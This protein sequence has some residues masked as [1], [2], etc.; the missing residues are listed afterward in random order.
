MGLPSLFRVSFAV[1]VVVL[2]VLIH[3]LTAATIN[4][5][6]VGGATASGH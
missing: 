1:I 4:V 2:R 5:G 3:T 6:G